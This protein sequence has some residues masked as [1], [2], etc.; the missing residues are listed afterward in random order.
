MIATDRAVPAMAPL[1]DDADLAHMARFVLEQVPGPAPDRLLLEK[2]QAAQTPEKIGIVTSL[3]KRR[4]F[5]ATGPLA[6]LAEDRDPQMAAA[7]L[8]AGPHRRCECRAG[9]NEVAVS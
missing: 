1:L 6:A 2:L 3:G 5:Q 7:A 4:V 9:V 8:C